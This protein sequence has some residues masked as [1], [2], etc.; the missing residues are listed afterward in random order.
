MGRMF[1]ILALIC[2]AALKPGVYED[3]KRIKIGLTDVFIRTVDVKAGPA[4]GVVFVV[5]HDD[6]NVASA[7]AEEIVQ[8]YGGR[9][10]E[11]IHRGTRRIEFYSG[12]R[13]Y[14]F[15]PNRIFTEEGLRATLNSDN[16][17][18]LG[19][20]R[21]FAALL[22]NDE[23]YLGGASRA[24]V[25]VHNNGDAGES[26]LSYGPGGRYEPD[27]EDVYVNSVRDADDFFFVTNRGVF[28]HFRNLGFNAVLQDNINV[29][30]DGSLS[31]RCREFCDG[32]SVL[33]LNA[34]AQQPGHLREQ[35][36]MLTEAVNF[37]RI[38]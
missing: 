24:V 35:V 5:L 14:S 4:S 38:P 20:V 1:W 30:D 25:A 32:Q 29:R 7:S 33:Y 13:R 9:L 10:V 8:N 34:E 12:G 26:V 3:K 16:E 19:H 37:L 23:R 6:E 22:F 27:V 18:A 31:V 11:L 28:E 15:D 17:Q 36:A 21:N 2:F